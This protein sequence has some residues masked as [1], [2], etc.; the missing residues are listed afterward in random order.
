MIT[1]TLVS[2]PL[3][4]NS[5]VM[6]TK[7]EFFYLLCIGIVFNALWGFLFWT[8]VPDILTI[9]GAACIVGA[10]IA[11]SSQKKNDVETKINN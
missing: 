8:E 7:L 1:A 3:M 5:F 9:I 2:I 10:C 4:W 6:P 11:L